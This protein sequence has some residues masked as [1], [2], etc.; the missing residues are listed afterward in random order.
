MKYARV[1]WLLVLA[2][3]LVLGHGA[4][5]ATSDAPPFGND[6]SAHFAAAM[7]VADVL[8]AGETDFWWH[9]SNMGVPLFAAYQPLPMLS[10]G[11]TLALLGPFIS[12]IVLFKFSILLTWALM[13]TAWYLGARW[14]GLPRATCVALGLLTLL[15]HDPYGIGFGVRSS[16]ERGLYTQHFGLLWLPLFAGA[17][18]RLFD[19]RDRHPLLASALFALTTMSHLWVG[20][21]AVL[22]GGTLALS[23]PHVVMQRV[24]PLGQFSLLS[25]SFMAWWLVPLVLT[26]EHAGGLPWLGE[27]HNGWAWD[28]TLRML[29]TGEVFDH[30]RLPIVSALCASGAIS[31]L[32]SGRHP[33]ARHW[34]LL[35]G[36]T[37]L[38]FLGRTN[39]G[40]LYEFIPMHD[41]VNVMRYLTGVHVCGLIAAAVAL[42]GAQ[43]WIASRYRRMSYGLTVAAGVALAIGGAR[44]MAPTLKTFSTHEPAFHG[45]VHYLGERPDHRIAVHNTL[46]TGSHF[47]RDLL[48][49]LTQR[50]QLQSYAHGYHCSL[51]TYY[52]EYFDFSPAA[53]DL[54]DIGSIVARHPLP[55]SFPAES[56]P[57]RW[58]NK[59]YTVFHPADRQ[60]SG[61]FALT[62]LSGAIE[63][64][65]LKSIRHAVKML[66]V[67]AYSLGTLPKIVVSN[68]SEVGVRGVDGAVKPWT[69]R[70][71]RNLL[72]S[73]TH[74]E[75]KESPD[76]EIRDYQRGRSSYRAT[77]TVPPNTKPWLLLKVNFFPWWSVYVDG[78]QTPIQHV[79]PNFMAVQLDQG[80]HEVAFVYA[81]PR[82]Q[83]LA[84]VLGLGL[85]V[86]QLRPWRRSRSIEA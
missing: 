60:Q 78:R 59:Q 38:L 27:T 50:G 51:S 68:V 77:V 74:R 82:S 66:S 41:Q 55:S 28:K 43:R 32:W 54:F 83:K 79:A 7:H 9:P 40:S 63:G 42:G 61:L 56:Y 24:R 13:P 1:E 5:W 37:G 49:F 64:P 46:G 70:E 65:D 45:L 23:K 31:I 33:H 34:I 44:D 15:V 85:F 84:L 2:F 17:F 16:T 69:R 62:H 67:P 36:A 52:A 14:Y 71:A 18:A 72:A 47:H 26:N 29:W 81:N 6:N 39:L 12:E 86:A 20:L 4:Q 30:T 76:G 8:A 48:P 73:I 22:I 10:M 11:A 75:R 53:C 57:A 35:T 3:V 25:F 19:G 80:E 21:Y 58:E